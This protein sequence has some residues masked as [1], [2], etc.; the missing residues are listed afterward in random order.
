MDRASAIIVC[1]MF[2]AWIWKI[3]RIVLKGLGNGTV[4]QK[5]WHCEFV[6]W[7]ITSFS[8]TRNLAG[9]RRSSWVEITEYSNGMDSVRLSMLSITQSSLEVT[10]LDNL[11][12]FFMCRDRDPFFAQSVWRVLSQMIVNWLLNP[13]AR[14]EPT[15]SSKFQLQKLFKCKFQLKFMTKQG[16]VRGYRRDSFFLS[17]FFNFCIGVG[18]VTFTIQKLR[19]LPRV[20]GFF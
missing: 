8:M 12:R 16:Y 9:K 15:F 13:S 6:I 11:I 17:L 14:F 2:G 10:V 5:I 18:H 4:R 19:D 7:C 1:V 20:L 3:C